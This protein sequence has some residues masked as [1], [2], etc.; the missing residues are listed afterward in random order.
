MGPRETVVLD[1]NVLVSALGWRGSERELYERC[2]T[3]GLEL[4]VSSALVAELERVLR[5]PKL[6]FTEDDIGA[7]VSDLLSHA[8]IV[9]P[10]RTLEVVE[11]DPDDDRVLECALSA[12]A[13]WIISGDKH[14]LGLGE[15]EGIRILGARAAL[16]TLGT[17]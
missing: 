10:P 9:S 12:G 17:D 8:I 1:T 13:R 6:G 16:E 7:F 11:E 15:H 3:G 5:Y 2:R 4:A 14:L